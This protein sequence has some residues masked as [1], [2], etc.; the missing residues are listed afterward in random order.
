MGRYA[1]LTTCM[2]DCT[3][4]LASVTCQ[5]HAMIKIGKR[6]IGI[7]LLIDTIKDLIVTRFDNVCEF[8]TANGLRAIN[9]LY[10]DHMIWLDRAM[11]N[12]TMQMFNSLGFVSCQL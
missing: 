5:D 1:K 11:I 12:T 9:T 8:D 7:E 2:T 6:P 4:D 3:F 10:L